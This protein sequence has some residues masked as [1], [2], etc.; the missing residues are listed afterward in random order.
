MSDQITSYTGLDNRNIDPRNYANT[1]AVE[2]FRVGLLSEDG[3]NILRSQ[4]MEGLAEIIK[5]Y[6]RDE[7]SS[8][9][10]DTAKE[11]AASMLYNIDTYLLTLNE[12]RKALEALTE[13]KAYELYGKGYAI[14]KKHYETARHL[15]GTARYNRIKN[16][17]EAYNKT[18]DQYF[19]YYLTHYDA[20]FNAHMKI[21][22]TLNEYGINGAYYVDEAV[23]VLNKLIAVSRGTPSD[24]TVEIAQ[25]TSDP[26]ATE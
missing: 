19:R 7:S 6:T 17:S 16:A 21:Y 15:Y 12:H 5:L 14:N 23:E 13:R 25:E 20:R 4:L 1:L 24:V 3:L 11:L 9:K 2:A 22:L 10:A 18:M 26:G 8:V